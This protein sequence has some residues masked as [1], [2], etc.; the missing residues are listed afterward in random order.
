MSVTRYDVV[1]WDR[2]RV[3]A[4][5]RD[6]GAWV[7]YDDHV[8]EVGQWAATVDR[9]TRERDDEHLA[10]VK[11]E[12]RERELEAVVDLTRVVLDSRFHDLIPTKGEWVRLHRSDIENVLL[13]AKAALAAVSAE[14]PEGHTRMND[15]ITPSEPTEWLEDLN[16]VS[17]ETED[18]S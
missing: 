7:K 5:P 15:G 16:A 14:T 3:D 4:L 10:R 13:R 12:A 1:P 6:G 9:V 2:Y 17:A 11:A 8:A 18:D